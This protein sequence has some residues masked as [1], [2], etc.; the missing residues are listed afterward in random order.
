MEA[1]SIT[2]KLIIKAAA[3]PRELKSIINRSPDL[4][5]FPRMLAI[6][7]AFKPGVPTIEA[8]AADGWFSFELAPYFNTP[9]K[10]L[11]YTD[12][13]YEAMRRNIKVLGLKGIVHA[14]KDD[15]QTLSSISNSSLGQVLL[16][17]VLEH[18]EDDS[19]AIQAVGRVLKKGGRFVISVP[20][21]YYPY[22]F[23]ERFDRI[24]G[25]QRHFTKEDLT[26]KLEAN[27]FE[28]VDYFY[29]TTVGASK[30]MKIWY[31]DLRVWP[32][33][34]EAQAGGP[35]LGMLSSLILPFLA[36]LSIM[37]DS[38]DKELKGHSS[39]CLTA[40]KTRS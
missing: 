18:V 15:A 7:K 20:T 17:D 30:L 16:V 13:E 39:L 31:R 14:G 11:A 6:K 36:A 19:A 2:D 1:F 21:P 4:H 3:R 32:K 29:Y 25:H 28:I 24:I 8:G 9:I 5:A 23:G 34:Y 12:A 35:K 37:L 33:E 26:A 38:Y 10:A 22:W 40:I 27:G